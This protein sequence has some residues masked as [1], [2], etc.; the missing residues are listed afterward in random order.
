MCFVKTKP[1]S[2]ELWFRLNFYMPRKI[3]TWPHGLSVGA[4]RKWTYL[5]RIHKTVF[6]LS[7]QI[8]PL[9]KQ[10]HNVFSSYRV[11]F[12]LLFSTV[13]LPRNRKHSLTLP[14]ALFNFGF[15]A[16]QTDGT[17]IL[18][19]MA[20]C[21]WICHIPL[22]SLLQEAF[23]TSWSTLQFLVSASTKFYY[24]SAGLFHADTLDDDGWTLYAGRLGPRLADNL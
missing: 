24:S 14:S 15:V 1:I 21:K 22:Q 10:H 3:S 17:W 4:W 9:P 7:P 12:R 8:L 6:L 5:T 23:W 19:S 16:T 2:T 11:I 13:F 20:H 18:Q